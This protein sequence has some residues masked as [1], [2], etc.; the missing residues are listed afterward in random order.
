VVINETGTATPT[1]VTPEDEGFLQ[2][3][4]GPPNFWPTEACKASAPAGVALIG[5]QAMAVSKR[6]AG[7]II[8]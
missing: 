5:D 4:T 7:L 8:P 1:I 3:V 2:H 6:Q